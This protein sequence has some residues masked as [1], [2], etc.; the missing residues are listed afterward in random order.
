[1]ERNKA[2]RGSFG[3]AMPLPASRARLPFQRAFSQA[4][5]DQIAWGLIPLQME[6]KW[7]IFL[8][9]DCLYFHRSWTGICVYQVA[10]ATRDGAAVVT[11]ALVN[12]DRSQYRG[13]DDAYEAALLAFLID[14]FLLGRRTPFPKPK[15]LPATA[16]A[17]LY[18]HH[19]SGSGY[20]E[21]EFRD[22]ENERN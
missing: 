16:P 13:A 5:Y 11:E 21:T 2:T 19:I 3:K 22:S 17:G 4:E 1:M 9:A 14:N 12:R 10:F 6:D 18:Q 7:F 8:E 15:H 20:P